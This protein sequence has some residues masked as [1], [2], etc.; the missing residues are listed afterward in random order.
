MGEMSWKH[1]PVYD[2]FK[3]EGKIHKMTRIKLSHNYHSLSTT[4]YPVYN[5]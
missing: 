2:N 1:A 3:V 4:G 5:R